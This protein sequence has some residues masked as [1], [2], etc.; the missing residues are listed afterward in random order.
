MNETQ[1]KIT[2]DNRRNRDFSKT[3]KA[4][5]N[6]YFAENNL[7]KF[8]NAA[9]IRKTI[10]LFTL[11][12]GSYALIISDILPVWGMWAMCFVM[13]LGMAGIGFSVSHDALHG[14]YSANKHVNRLLGLSFDLLG[15]N[16][17]IWKITHNVIHHT[18]TNIQGHDEDLE[19]AGF[20][21]LSPN[22]E[23]QPIHRLQHLLA[24]PAYSFATFFW[25]FIKDYKYFLQ[26]DLG[27][28]KDKKHPAS[29]WAILIVT[30][31]IYYGYIIA[32][33][34]LLLDITWLQF[35]IGFFTLHLTAGLT[36]GIIFQLAH[37]VEDTEHPVADTDD[38]IPE[39]WL[40]HQMATTADFAQDNKFLCWYIGGLNFQIEHHLFPRIC[41]I[42]YPDIASIVRQTAREYGVPYHCYETFGDA[43][44]SHYRT[45][46]RFG[47]AE[48]ATG[49]EPLQNS[50]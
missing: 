19:V 35:A 24:F 27:P 37:I 50:I 14:A 34:M 43:V 31:L 25:V 6:A 10:A 1:R 39:H 26:R 49:D 20:I 36:L 48:K 15:A 41:S 2:F 40:V 21:R 17:Y 42:H 33:P 46:K 7:S 29:E 32:V 44:G 38:T 45:L 9:M 30:K 28:Y 11:Y 12:F 5:V 13:G 16:G 18:Y 8:A 22:T 47:S 3:V 23:H 4:R